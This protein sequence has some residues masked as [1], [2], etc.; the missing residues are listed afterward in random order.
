MF[1]V[2]SICIASIALLGVKMYD[3]HRLLLLYH[4]RFFLGWILIAQMLHNM[5]IRQITIEVEV[6]KFCTPFHFGR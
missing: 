4:S 3:L 6:P 2:Y 5:S 1:L